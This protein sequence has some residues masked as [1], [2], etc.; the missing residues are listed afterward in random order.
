MTNTQTL[1]YKVYPMEKDKPAK[2]C[3][4]WKIQ[5]KLPAESRNGK[6][7]YPKKRK[8]FN[9]SYREAEVAAEEFK[10]QLEI[11]LRNFGKL[12]NG[13]YFLSSYCRDFYSLKSERD[14]LDQKSL[15]RIKHAIDN[16]LLNHED[17]LVQQVTTR[18][19]TDALIKLKEGNSTSRKKLQPATLSKYLM[20]WKQIFEQACEDGLIDTNPAARIKHIKIPKP[21]KKALTLEQ[22]HKLYV[23]L[24]PRNRSEI[25]TIISLYC[26]LRQSEV[27]NL[28]WADID[29]KNK[30]LRVKKSKTNAGVREIP[31]VEEVIESLKT[32]KAAAQKEVETYNHEQTDE[33]YKLELSNEGYV[34]SCLDGTVKCEA[35]MLTQWWKR[36]KER[37]G[38]EEFTFHELRHTFATLLAKADVHPSIMQKF[39]GHST[40]RLSLEVYTHVHQE[41]MEAAKD[42]LQLIIK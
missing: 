18:S 10:K 17:V 26:G 6:M 41:D 22:A 12:P 39:L 23:Q 40:S 27:L 30:T 14:G 9:G 38:F 1:T 42:K 7:S 21:N 28:T 13:R 4:K 31:I 20:Y 19:L 37:L 2:K 25:G 32:R 34:C 29:F 36:N 3:K 35:S 16:L 33:K 24:D 8:V 5:V 15:E 11:D